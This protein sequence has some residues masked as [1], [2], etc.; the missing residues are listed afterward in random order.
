MKLHIYID[1]VFF[2]NFCMNFV[3]LLF[4][5]NL[6][7]LSSSKKRLLLSSGVIS[8]IYC[9]VLVY[10]K[11]GKVNK[12]ILTILLMSISI[13]ISFKVKSILEFIK[14]FLSMYI[15]SVI[16]GGVSFSI[17]YLIEKNSYLRAVKNI[18]LYKFPI[19][20]LF[21][22]VIFT[23]VALK[24]ILLIFNKYFITGKFYLVE[25]LVG[26]DSI[27]AKAILDTGNNLREPTTLKPVILI[28]ENKILKYILDK[29]IKLEYKIPFK[30]VGEDNGEILAFQSDK[31]KI[32]SK[33]EGNLDIDN[34]IIGVYKG[35]FTSDD[36]YNM[37]LNPYI[38]I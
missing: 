22:S 20:V 15:I 5:K 37:L 29:K 9:I 25:I 12:L 7:K 31:V 24:G 1:V 30:S 8:L 32:I 35:N 2:I 26:K 38:F 16:V 34:Q 18:I 21:I 14:V 6:C 33:S 3:I 36:N 13:F 27:V 11:Y 23:Y 4:T 28:E 10:I 17:Y 19:K